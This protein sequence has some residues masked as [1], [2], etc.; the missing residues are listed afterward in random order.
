MK[1]ADIQKLTVY[2][3]V[4]ELS[5]ENF[6]FIKDVYSSFEGALEVY[7]KDSEESEKD[8]YLDI[9]YYFDTDRMNWV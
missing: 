4:R 9:D 5:K 7:K 8:D 2:E 6:D 3:F 1:N